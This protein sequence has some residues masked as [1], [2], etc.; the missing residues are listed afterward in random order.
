MLARG[1]AT[2]G[3]G[4]RIGLR[5]ERAQPVV[6]DPEETPWLTGSS[7]SARADW[8]V[9]EH[10]V[11]ERSDLLREIRFGERHPP[12]SISLG[13]H[14]VYH[15]VGDGRLIAIMTVTSSEAR[16]DAA[17][18]WEK[19]WPLVL[20]VKPTLR[21][22]RVST[23]PPTSVLGLNDDLRHQS[24][25]PLTDTQYDAAVAALRGSGAR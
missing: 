17:R 8:K 22:G 16:Y 15:A 18:E 5:E 3:I 2:E 24:F 23:G 10:W 7:S 13:D 19:Q 9:P 14:L 6:S 21:V 4:D 1:H 11:H 12:D 25:V 20:D